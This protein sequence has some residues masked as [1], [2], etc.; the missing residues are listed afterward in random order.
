MTRRVYLV[1]IFLVVWT[2]PLITL[3]GCMSAS[4]DGLSISSHFSNH[5][6]RTSTH[7]T[8]LQKIHHESDHAYV[9]LA[10]FSSADQNAIK[11][12]FEISENS[13][14]EDYLTYAAL[15]NPGLKASFH[16]W[17]AALERIVQ[18]NTLPDPDNKVRSKHL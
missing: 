12:T 13:G 15:N 18:A 17:K 3:A 2:L 9:R 1:Y 14:L 6:S 7:V 4:A 10:S 16:R 5:V 11:N 8:S